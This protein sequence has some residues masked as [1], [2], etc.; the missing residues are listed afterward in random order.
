[1]EKIYKLLPHNL[2]DYSLSYKSPKQVGDTLL[3][4]HELLSSL[5]IL[6]NIVY[7]KDDI[8][9]VVYSYMIHRQLG[10]MIELMDYVISALHIH[11]LL[12]A[13]KKVKEMYFG[14]NKETMYMEFSNM[15]KELRKTKTTLYRSK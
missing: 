14:N 1:M 7:T 3:F 8:K 15:R 10:H 6:N 5:S 13:Y 9:L 2:M 11:L 12:K 4:D